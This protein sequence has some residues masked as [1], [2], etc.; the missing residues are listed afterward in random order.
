MQVTWSISVQ[1]RGC[2]RGCMLFIVK[3]AEH[4]RG[5]EIID[6]AYVSSNLFTFHASPA[7]VSEHPV[8]YYK[9]IMVMRSV[10]RHHGNTGTADKK[11]SYAP[12]KIKAN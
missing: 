3:K 7:V 8:F 9:L 2:K 10:V 4:Q 12:F 5:I 6:I 11:N 1:N